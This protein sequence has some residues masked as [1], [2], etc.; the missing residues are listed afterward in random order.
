MA[1]ARISSA[2]LHR[3]SPETTSAATRL[4]RRRCLSM[5]QILI[6]LSENPNWEDGQVESSDIIDNIKAK[7]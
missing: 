6:D 1:I 3:L 2:D 4:K 7:A 5:F